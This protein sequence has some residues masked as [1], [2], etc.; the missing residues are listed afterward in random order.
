MDQNKPNIALRLARLGA[1]FTQEE[2]SGALDVSSMTVYRWEAGRQTPSPFQRARLCQLFRKS[3]HELGWLAEQE[4][5]LVSSRFPLL[6]PSLPIGCPVLAGQREVLQAI[7]SHF[8]AGCAPRTVGITGLPGSGKTALAAALPGLPRLQHHFDGVMWATLG[9]HPSRHQHMQRW[10]ALLGLEELPSDSE[11]ARAMIQTAIGRRRMLIVLDDL[12][13]AYDYR[14]YQCGSTYCQY[15]ITTRQVSLARTIS[16]VVYRP[17]S[18][19]TIQAIHVLE[20]ALPSEYAREYRSALYALAARLGNLP[21]ALEVAA[22]YLR[23]ESSTDSR[24][25]I[26]DAISRLGQPACYLRLGSLAQ[27]SLVSSIQRSDH[28][29]S[30]SARQAFR[31]LATSFPPAPATFSEKQA[32][33]ALQP[34]EFWQAAADLDRLL[35]SGLLEPVGNS[36]YQLHPVLAD[37]ARLEHD[38]TP[39]V[40]FSAS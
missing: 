31:C 33:D 11:E 5:P 17:A 15:L 20:S 25:R 12:W 2:L 9:Q 6:D 21:L 36:R 23:R 13:E 3:E 22:T 34:G 8:V 24:R 4:E 37:F 26:A 27:G 16:E 19:H 40:V 28:W 7:Q 30:A 10:A 18:L 1:G 35:D 29:L 38:D 39:D 32:F 14:A